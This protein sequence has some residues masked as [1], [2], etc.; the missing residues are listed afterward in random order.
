MLGQCELKHCV[1]IAFDSL[2]QGGSGQLR[3]VAVPFFPL[4]MKDLSCLH[5]GNETKIDGLINFEKLRMLSHEMME[6]DQ[7]RQN[8]CVP[9]TPLKCSQH[10]LA[11]CSFYM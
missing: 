8:T 11:C 10:L 2:L 9:N 3:V 6:L 5:L 7:H 4:V 1:C